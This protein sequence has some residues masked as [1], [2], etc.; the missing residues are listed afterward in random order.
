[1]A[2]KVDK[3]DLT[4][5]DQAVLYLLNNTNKYFNN[6]TKLLVQKVFFLINR[7]LDD[8]YVQYESLHYG[9]YSYDLEEILE[10]EEDWGLI[11]TKRNLTDQGKTILEQINS[12]SELKLILKLIDE[13]VDSLKDLNEED[14]TYL[15]YHLYPDF[16]KDSRIIA[17][18]NSYKLETATINLDE[19]GSGKSLN[20]KTDKNNTVIVKK[21][22]DNLIEIK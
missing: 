20:I 19:I 11:T 9:M 4:E 17:E 16:T 8:K 3:C 10:K 1:M 6:V 5:A 14:I 21:V 15:L 18:V 7:S 22:R 12:S 2:D 13:V